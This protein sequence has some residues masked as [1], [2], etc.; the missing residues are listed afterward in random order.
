MA[1][2]Q[3]REFRRELVAK[4][5]A[6]KDDSLVEAEWLRFCDAHKH[7]YLSA[8]L[9]HNRVLT[10]LN[11][12]GLLERTLHRRK[13]LLRAKNIACCETH[14]EAIETIFNHGLI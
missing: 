9:G 12:G 1:Q 6:V 11:S 4:S 3:E 5:T 14:R 7:G 8:M 13:Q 2:E 10:K